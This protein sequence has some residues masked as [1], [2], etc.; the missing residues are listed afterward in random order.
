MLD[1]SSWGSGLKLGTVLGHGWLEHGISQ[2]IWSSKQRSNL[3]ELVN[4]GYLKCLG[5]AI[6]GASENYRHEF[7][8][9]QVHF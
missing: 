3:F 5:S 8:I 1:S 6:K 2:E 7:L 4:A 9:C